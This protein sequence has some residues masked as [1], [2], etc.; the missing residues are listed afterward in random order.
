MKARTKIWAGVGMC[1]L[2]AL[3]AVPVVRTGIRYYRV[4]KILAARGARERVAKMPTE[5]TIRRSASTRPTNLAYAVCDLGTI[6]S[7][8]IEAKGHGA[9]LL[10]SNDR[11]T[12]LF[13]TPFSDPRYVPELEAIENTH[14][15]SLLR[16]AG[17]SSDEF[18]RYESLIREKAGKRDWDEVYAFTAPEIRGL[19]FI[20]DGRGVRLRASITIN[21]LDGTKGVVY[22]VTLS[23]D[24]RIDM[25]R[26]LDEML[27]SFRFTVD[28]IGGEAHL[29][30]LIARNGIAYRPTTE[31][32]LRA[33]GGS[34]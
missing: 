32:A 23:R 21:S 31:P 11:A 3:V 28:K 5:R 22:H 2:A 10:V 13:M 7:A 30:Q 24:A 14:E 1:M 27:G 15:L 12:I 17:L 19:A 29:K 16:L 25:H 8:T 9:S 26:L 4:E 33:A 20:G 34:R 6:G 18:G